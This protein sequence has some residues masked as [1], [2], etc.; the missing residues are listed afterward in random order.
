PVASQTSRWDLG[1]SCD[2]GTRQQLLMY[3]KATEASSRKFSVKTSV[4]NASPGNE[5]LQRR[6]PHKA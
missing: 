5:L 4:H 3:Q 1:S 2:L 6:K